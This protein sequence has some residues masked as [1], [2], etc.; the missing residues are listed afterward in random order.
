MITLKKGHLQKIL[1]AV[2]FISIILTVIYYNRQMQNIKV[3]NKIKT[4]QLTKKYTEKYTNLEKL[5]N[6]IILDRENSLLK[7]SLDI[8]NLNN[9]IE[10]LQSY[11]KIKNIDEEIQNSPIFKITAYDLSIA[12]CGKSRTARGF[13][14]TASGYNLAGQD[15][16][17][18]STISTD[19]NIIPLGTAVYLYFDINSIYNGIYISSDT[20]SGI[21]GNHIDLFI[22]DNLTTSQ[23]L[24][25]GVKQAKV[26]KLDEI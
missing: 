23:A 13:G 15:L 22:G 14:I 16:R 10:K 18:A 25:F 17:T 8:K 12:S 11:L 5:T 1:T 26:I 9:K 21:R 2:A 24:N 4:V 6:K 7:K 20:G 3:Q 19:P